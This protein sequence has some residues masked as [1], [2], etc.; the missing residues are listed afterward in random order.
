MNAARAATPIA[1][2]SVVLLAVAVIT[3][4]LK[5]DDTTLPDVAA[6]SPTRPPLQGLR[7]PSRPM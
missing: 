7:Q 6:P 2:I 1:V 5:E 4:V 3:L